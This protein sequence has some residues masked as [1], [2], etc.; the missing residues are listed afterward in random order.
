MTT[1][2]PTGAVVH[3]YDDGGRVAAGYKGETGDCGCRAVS[4]AT[5]LPYQDVYDLMIRYAK[6]ERTSSRKRTRSHPRTGYHSAT[7]MRMLTREFRAAWTPTMRPGSGTTVHVRADELP[8]TGRHVLRL[9]K[10]YAAYV[11]GILRDT[12]DP[13]RDGTRAVYG[14]WTVP[15][16]G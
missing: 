8:A 12:H 9:S 3:V 10:H 16:L 15:V 7:L 1:T 4:I 11:D 13:S 14:Y 2:A 6:T 5:G